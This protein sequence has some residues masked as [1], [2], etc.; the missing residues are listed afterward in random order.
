MQLAE[1]LDG[2]ALPIPEEI[3]LSDKGK[4]WFRFR[5][6]SP[7]KFNPIVLQNLVADGFQVIKV[8]EMK[9]S[10]ESVYLQAVN[11]TQLEDFDDV[12]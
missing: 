5:V 12:E 2:R 6:R 3:E 9:R 1:T 4:D 11:Q 10:L 8:E 7:D